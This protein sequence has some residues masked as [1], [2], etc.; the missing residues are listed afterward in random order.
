MNVNNRRLGI[1]QEFFLVDQTG[2]LSQQA[3]AFLQACRE[4]AAAQGIPPQCY[5]PEF[6]KSLVEINTVPAASLAELTT[7]YLDVLDVA[8]AAAHSLQLRLYPLATY[9]LYIAPVQ[10][11]E[12]LYHLQTRA[13]GQQTFEHAARCAGTHLHLELSPG[14]VDRRIGIAYDSTA[15]DR[16]EVV[17]LFN[18]ATALDAA[19]ITLSR[20]CP[21]YNGK[22]ARTATRTIH[23]RGSRYHGWEGV[24]T[25]HPILGAL[26]PYAD[27]A[28]AVVEQ[29]FHRY[30]TWLEAMDRANVPRQRFEEA[31]GELLTA[32]WNPVRLNRQ[33]T[34]ELR[35]MDSNFPEVTLALI[36]LVVHAARRVRHECLAVSP[37]A[38]LAQFKLQDSVL[39]VP[40]FETL[41]QTLLYA[42]ATEGIESP[43]VR[44]YL[45]SVLA[46]AAGGAAS[47]AA[48]TSTEAAGGAIA[49]FRNSLG[50]YQT[51]EAQLFDQFNTATGTLSQ[52]EGLELVRHCCDQ[53]ESQV[54]LLRQQRSPQVA[55]SVSWQD[56]SFD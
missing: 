52:D 38:G 54:R 2:A 22:L 45:D 23:Y 31:G 20:A 9:P 28:A 56:V 42:A 40:D 48:G 29:I 44:D 11:D 35:A 49:Q 36:T 1:E 5:V 19:L 47:A 55:L 39:Q 14:V 46:F 37:Q 6:V 8:I 3:D 50:N 12:L 10:R 41:H 16:A 51:T 33:G 18:L 25:Q 15:G 4:Q 21:F 24:Y 30:H 27:G 26:L 34:L 7:Q 32:G 13:L 53:L 17:N 43:L